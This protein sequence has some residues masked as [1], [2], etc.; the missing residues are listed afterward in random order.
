ME[1]ESVRKKIYF[2]W[3]KSEY[4]RKSTALQWL[5]SCKECLMLDTTS[6][7]SLVTKKDYSWFIYW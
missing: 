6:K 4:V 5:K 2:V 1:N 7:K 3:E